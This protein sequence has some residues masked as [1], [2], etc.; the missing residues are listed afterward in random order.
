MTD[1]DKIVKSIWKLAEQRGWGV[2]VYDK[3]NWCL[4]HSNK[5]ISVG[6]LGLEKYKDVYHKQIQQYVVNKKKE[7]IIYDDYKELRIVDEW[8]L[9]CIRKEIPEAKDVEFRF[10]NL[11]SLLFNKGEQN[12]KQIILIYPPEKP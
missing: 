2:N 10:K 4:H 12:I 1:C 3:E 8:L 9:D 7:N 5:Y 11:S 6:R